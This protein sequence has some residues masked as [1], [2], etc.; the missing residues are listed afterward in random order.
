MY[1]NLSLLKFGVLR[2]VPRHSGR[3]S[4]QESLV[5]RPAVEILC[6]S[7]LLFNTF[8]LITITRHSQFCS[9]YSPVRLSLTG[10]R[11]IHDRFYLT[12]ITY[13]EQW[14]TML[15]VVLI[16]FNYFYT[17]VLSPTC[18][19][20]EEDIRVASGDAIYAGTLT[21]SPVSE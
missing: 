1:I 17:F 2:I 13:P 20:Y 8:D 19:P 12:M 21:P 18:D 10:V 16:L 14:M 11:D 9:F 4:H 3:R 6:R 15:T 7:S 5:L